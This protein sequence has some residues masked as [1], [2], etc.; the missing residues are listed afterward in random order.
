MQV[1]QI[2]DPLEPAAE[3]VR[4]C[5]QKQLMTIYRVGAYSDAEDLLRKIATARGKLKPGGIPMV[6][7]CFHYASP[8]TQSGAKTLRSRVVCRAPVFS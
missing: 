1:E 3:V 4:R 8:D 5:E 7:V 2:E 6:E